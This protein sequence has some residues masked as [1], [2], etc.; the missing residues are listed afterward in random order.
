MNAG[1]EGKAVKG[2]LRYLY[3]EAI[4]GGRVYGTC[5]EQ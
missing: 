1:I 4:K 3:R 2:G 5:T